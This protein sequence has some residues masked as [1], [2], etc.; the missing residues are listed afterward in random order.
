MG[1]CLQSPRLIGAERQVCSHERG[2]NQL[3]DAYILQTEARQ[4]AILSAKFLALR[5]PFNKGAHGAQHNGTG[6]ESK[7]RYIGASDRQP[8]PYLGVH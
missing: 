5:S 1:F 3:A 8:T 7:A 4:S 2:I 6:R